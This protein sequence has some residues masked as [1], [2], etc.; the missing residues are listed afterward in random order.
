MA[1]VE[2]DIETGAAVALVAATAKT[3]L[4]VAATAN[5]GT[6]LLRYSVGFDGVTATDKSV[7][8]EICALTAATNSVA[9]T[10]NTSATAAIQQTRGR[11]IAAAHTAG[12]G[13][14]SEPTVL[15]KIRSFMLSPIGGTIFYDF[16]LDNLPDNDVSKG[17]A[18]RCTAPT[19][20]V[21]VRGALGFARI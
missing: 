16:P 17:F 19:S 5:F 9:G 6:Q 4:F 1:A 13:C 21:N 20:A 11:A 14:T 7:Y 18:I 2:Y 12:Y 8:V 15:T 3:I 10:G